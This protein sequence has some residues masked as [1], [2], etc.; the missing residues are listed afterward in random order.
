MKESKGD[1]Y[2][3]HDTE[4]SL[5]IRRDRGFSLYFVVDRD[6]FEVTGFSVSLMAEDGSRI[7]VEMSTEELF[8]LKSFLGSVDCQSDIPAGLL[9]L[10]CGNSPHIALN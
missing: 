2:Y 5:T 8:A 1:Q 4:T 10:R 9:K 6:H 7:T 3:D